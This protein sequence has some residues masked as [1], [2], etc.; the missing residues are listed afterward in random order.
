[1]CGT[2]HSA[3]EIVHH[4][5]NNLESRA[6]E[7][8]NEDNSADEDESSFRDYNYDS[9]SEDSMCLEPDDAHDCDI[10][11]GD[12]ENNE[13]IKDSDHCTDSDKDSDSEECRMLKENQRKRHGL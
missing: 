10:D 12:V 13:E 7:E 6:A 1:M 5:F 4:Y 2:R 9:D 11:F 8:M 3:N